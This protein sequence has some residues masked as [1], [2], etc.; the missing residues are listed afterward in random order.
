MQ[1]EFIRTHERNYVVALKNFSENF[2][3]QNL[4]LLYDNL[5]FKI[6]SVNL[7]YIIEH[8]TEHL[9]QLLRFPC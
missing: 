8:N 7:P 6:I 4:H 9:T 1:N 5:D 3:L 2:P